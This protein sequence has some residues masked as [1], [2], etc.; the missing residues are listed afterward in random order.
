MNWRMSKIINLNL[1]KIMILK[2]LGRHITSTEAKMSLVQNSAPLTFFP[3]PK[4][5]K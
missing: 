3:Y 2:M 1:L 4:G 5:A